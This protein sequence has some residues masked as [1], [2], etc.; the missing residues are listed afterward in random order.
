MPAKKTK[1]ITL[2]KPVQIVGRGILFFIQVL[3]SFRPSL[4]QLKAILSQVYFIG[5]RSLVIIMVCG[6]FVGM[7]LTLQSY[8]ELS[9]FGATDSVGTVLAL[10]L[11]R[12]LGPV[13]TAL[14]FSGRAGTS[15]AAEIGLM[16]ATEQ[17]SAMELMA[18]DPVQRVV[19]PRFFA[20]VICVP[21]LT[22]LFNL[23]AIAGGV[24][25]AVYI[26]GVDSG[27]FWSNML[28]SVEFQRDFMMSFWKSLVFGIVATFIAVFSGY[29]TTPTGDGIGRATTQTVVVTAVLVLIFD[30]IITALMSWT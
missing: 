25:Y 11:F 20:G 27:I 21:L 12:E 10:S 4:K 26:M 17:L 9:K 23:T 28:S 18:I 15:I 8:L 1:L 19:V 7:V 24:A 22:A 14:L 2:R 16:K 30:F 29:F 6:F 5:T 3:T 13:L